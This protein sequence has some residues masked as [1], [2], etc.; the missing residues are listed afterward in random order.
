M[1]AK[2]GAAVPDLTVQLVKLQGEL[3]MPLQETL[4]VTLGQI[5]SPSKTAIP[6]MTKL[7]GRDVFFDQM[8]RKSIDQILAASEDADLPMLIRLLKNRDEA[9]RLRAAKALGRL[10]AEA[11]SAVPELLISLN[12]SDADVR[13]A[14]LKALGL[15]VGS[16]RVSDAI[17]V[18][19]LDLQDADVGFRFRAAKALATYGK[20]AA[21]A[22]PALQ[23]AL[24]DPDKDVRRAITDAITIIGG[25]N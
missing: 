3:T 8:V 20:D 25:S 12:D 1:G 22:L 13:R 6:T 17:T 14:T 15:I 11:K 10:G 16:T 19:I 18:L 9:H 2:A 24:N 21:A 4:V 5:G 23:S 7:A